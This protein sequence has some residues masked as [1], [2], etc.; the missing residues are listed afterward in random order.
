MRNCWWC[1]TK[2]MYKLHRNVK[3]YM[4]FYYCSHFAQE[5]ANVTNIVF[6]FCYNY[7]F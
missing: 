2:I 1:M 5:F 4:M 6:T 3:Y 7:K